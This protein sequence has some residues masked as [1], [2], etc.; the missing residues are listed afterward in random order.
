M[1]TRQVQVQEREQ[2]ILSLNSQLSEFRQPAM[3]MA[4]GSTAGATSWPSETAAAAE[5][6][7]SPSAYSSW[8]NNWNTSMVHSR[9]PHMAG[10]QIAHEEGPQSA[11]PSHAR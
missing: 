9:D 8:A 11:V 2:E 6:L 10:L 7:R 3:A 4:G 5:P 1:L